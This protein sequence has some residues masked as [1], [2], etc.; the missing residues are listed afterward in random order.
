MVVLDL[1]HSSGASPDANIDFRWNGLWT[2]VRP[3]QIL[4]AYIAGVE[5]CLIFS[6][7][8]DGRN[9]LYEVGVSGEDDYAEGIQKKVVGQFWTR[10][11]AFGDRA[12]RHVLKE[13]NGGEISVSELKERGS[14]EIEYRKDASVCWNEFMPPK[15]IGCDVCSIDSCSPELSEQ[16][17]LRIKLPTP[18][19][20]DCVPGQGLSR[21]GSEFQ[22][23]ITTE[24][25]YAIDRFRISAQGNIPDSPTS[26]CG[27]D[28]CEK[29]ICCPNEDY[30]IYS[31]I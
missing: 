31:I 17:Y 8:S 12:A 29:I 16:R 11:Y 25:R 21:I 9:R 26:T 4:K 10:R 14:I 27:E 24:G 1:D 15:I 6:Y 19:N 30:D 23:R 5:R 7:D 2:G 18:S 3:I 28:N 20:K 22:I 13:L